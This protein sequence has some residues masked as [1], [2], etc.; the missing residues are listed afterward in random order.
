[1][2]GMVSGY[3]AAKFGKLAAIAVGGSMLVI[4]VMFFFSFMMKS[5]VILT[6]IILFFLQIA[7]YNDYIEIDWKKVNQDVQVVKKTM[8]KNKSQLPTV[9]KNIQEFVK[10]NVVLAGG[11]ASGFLIGFAWA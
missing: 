5:F 10:E 3:L 9:V 1:M 11:F 8:N 2:G 6:Y 4:Q 7:Q